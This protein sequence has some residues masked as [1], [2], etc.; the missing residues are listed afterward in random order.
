MDR[1]DLEQIEGLIS[2]QVGTFADAVQHKLDLVV[3]GHQMLADKMDRI[4]KRLDGRIDCVIRK[5][6]S[7][8]AQ[9]D[10][11]AAKLDAVAADL[12]AHRVD[13]EAHHPV[14]RVKE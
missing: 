10:A 1:K 2:R 9:G 14:Y 11:T 5:L 12:K 13:T 4:E 7:V 8:A 3:E 6:D